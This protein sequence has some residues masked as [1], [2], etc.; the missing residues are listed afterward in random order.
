MRTAGTET[1]DLRVDD[2]GIELFRLLIRQPEPLDG[3]GREI[4]D[5]DVRPP[6]QVLD[7]GKPALRFE[8]GRDG[9]LV[10]VE[11]QKIPGILP[12]RPAE[13]FATGIAQVRVLDLDYLGTEPSQRLGACRPG[14]ELREIENPDS[15]QIVYAIRGHR[16]DRSPKGII[17][18]TCAAVLG[19]SARDDRAP[20]PSRG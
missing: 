13:G 2:T 19:S 9:L 15:G 14:L 3:A 1:F 8:V 16:L 5:A 20:P 10:G 7:Q 4:L 6:Q 17:V 18:R 12:G 11:Q